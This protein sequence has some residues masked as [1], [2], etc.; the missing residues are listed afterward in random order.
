MYVEVPMF[1]GNSMRAKILISLLA[2]NLAG[3]NCGAMDY[4]KAGI[5]VNLL[6]TGGG[7]EA[8]CSEKVQ[9][10]YKFW[11]EKYDRFGF[12]SRDDKVS[13]E[14]EKDYNNRVNISAKDGAMLVPFPDPDIKKFNEAKTKRKFPDTF[15]PRHFENFTYPELK[16]KLCVSMHEDFKNLL[17]PKS[18]DKIV[19]QRGK[20][21]EYYSSGKKINDLTTYFDNIEIRKLLGKIIEYGKDT[22]K[23][24]KIISE[25][26]DLELTNVGILIMYH[27]VESFIRQVV[28]YTISH[29]K[30]KFE[31]FNYI[32]IINNP[33]AEFY[34]IKAKMPFGKVIDVWTREEFDRRLTNLRPILANWFYKD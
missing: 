7:Q 30:L 11:I 10:V 29:E 24:A 28:N 15:D 14:W 9:K 8:F 32:E 34:K 21:L 12:F 18:I 1:L 27:M 23:F 3:C 22:D 31:D 4:P 13:P 25:L 17:V 6:E 5:T 20:A 16:E 33:R 26:N 19:F 2:L